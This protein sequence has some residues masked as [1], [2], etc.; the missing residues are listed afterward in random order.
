MSLALSR[1]IELHSGKIEIDGV[2]ISQVNIH[3]L[4]DKVTVIPQ[5]PTLFKGTLRFNID[6]TNRI[7]DDQEIINML[8]EAGLDSLLERDDKKGL[9]FEVTDNGS[10]LSS[11]EKQLLCIC[12]SI[13]RKN[14][15]V[16][17]DE[18]TANIDVVTEQKIQTLI[19]KEF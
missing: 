11:G 8:K 5:D 2:D 6:P 19:H 9:N 3:Q 14:R 4:R 18:A 1:I 10:N 15:V 17:L 12:R 7:K 16:V 13:L